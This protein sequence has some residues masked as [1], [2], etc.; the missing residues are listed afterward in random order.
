MLR[1][2]LLLLLCLAAPVRSADLERGRLLYESRCTACH[3][4]SV[5]LRESRRA[6]DYPG[7]RA[8]VERWSREAGVAW[9]RD[10]LDD[11][12][13]FLNDRYYRFNCRAGRCGPGQAG[14]GGTRIAGVDGP[15]AGA[16]QH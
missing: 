10:E 6:P 16:T 12:T 1:A 9:T 2:V 4:R 8:Q 11:V 3:A 5:H 14:A 13:Y 7:V 15:A